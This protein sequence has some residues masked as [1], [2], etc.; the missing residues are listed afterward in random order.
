MGSV[1]SSQIVATKLLDV[2]SGPGHACCNKTLTTVAAPGFCR[3]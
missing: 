2:L 3:F 1:D